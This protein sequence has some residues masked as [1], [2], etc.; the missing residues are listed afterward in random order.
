VGEVDASEGAVRLQSIR[1]GNAAAVMHLTCQQ[2][3]P[4]RVSVRA[5]RWVGGWVGVVGYGAEVCEEG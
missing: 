2:V 5:R 4:L 1:Q 3:Q